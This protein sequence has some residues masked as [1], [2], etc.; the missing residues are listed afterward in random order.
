MSKESFRDLITE[1]TDAIAG[2]PIDDGLAQFLNQRFPAEG[3]RFRAIADACH[4]AITEGW[5]CKHEDGGIRFGRIV[6]PAEE[7]A[8]FSVDVVQM[9]DVE[10]PHHRHPNGE[11][12]MIM[13]ITETALFDGHGAG[14]YVY[15]PDTAHHPTVSGGAALVLYL[16]PGG[17]IEFT[18]ASA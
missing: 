8:G 18:G 12:D 9:A 3:D 15:G 14:W 13:P 7:T 6:K 2:K 16:L 1:V 11:I 5:M 10:G 4:A 17:A